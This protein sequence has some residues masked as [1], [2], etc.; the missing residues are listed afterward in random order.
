MKKL[1]SP[2]AFAMIGVLAALVLFGAFSAPSAS[3]SSGTFNLMV[4]HGINGNDL[5]LDKDLPVNVF[6]NGSLAVPGFEFGESVSTSLASGDYTF[7]VELL[8]GTPLP[9]MTLGPVRIPA[10]VDVDV[11]ARLDD[12]GTPYL[13]A[14]ISETPVVPDA[15]DLSVKHNID[16]NDLG[17]VSELPVNVFINGQLALPGFTYGDKISTSLDAGTYTIT[18]ELLDGTP[19][20]SM[21]LENVEIP[22]GAKI[23]IK[24]RLIG[25]VPTLK[26]N[27]H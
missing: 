10:G 19:L 3:A 4:F 14:R 25:G 11:K 21:T 5:G 15:F 1:L 16:G 13:R 6:A 27:I 17:V 7:T 12:A 23:A 26:V 9:S 22:A 2:K 18:V 20:P 8:D 24:A